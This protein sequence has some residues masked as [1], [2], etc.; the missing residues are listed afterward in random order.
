MKYIVQTIYDR[1][2]ICSS[3]LKNILLFLH[4]STRGADLNPDELNEIYQHVRN[5]FATHPELNNG[6]ITELKNWKLESGI[7]KIDLHGNRSEAWHD[8]ENTDTVS[9]WIL[10]FGD[11]KIGKM[12]SMIK[13]IPRTLAATERTW[14]L[15][16]AIHTKTRN[17]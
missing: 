1:L 6:L 16:G 17:R 7:F 2:S 3:P 5:S 8:M 15:R 13:S 9:W 4:P 12:L 11:T 14:S 10:Y